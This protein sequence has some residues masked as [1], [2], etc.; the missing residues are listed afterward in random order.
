MS[1]P[2]NTTN[3]PEPTEEEM[4][5]L[6]AAIMQNGLMVQQLQLAV[7]L[8]QKEIRVERTGFAGGSEEAKRAKDRRVEKE[9]EGIEGDKEKGKKG[10]ESGEAHDVTSKRSLDEGRI[11]KDRYS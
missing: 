1:L 5:I 9:G 11:R 10:G 8:R 2:F 3:L 4:K 6:M 7:A